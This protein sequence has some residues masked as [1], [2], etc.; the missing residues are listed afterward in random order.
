VALNPQFVTVASIIKLYGQPVGG[1]VYEVKLDTATM[2]SFSPF[3]RLEQ[4]NEPDGVILRFH[5]NVTIEGEREPDAGPAQLAKT[6]DA[7][8]A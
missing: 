1:G 2:A 6:D 4:V 5:P 3:S 8:A 7:P